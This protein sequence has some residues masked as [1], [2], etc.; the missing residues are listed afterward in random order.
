MQSGLGVFS[1]SEAKIDPK[2]IVDFS[3]PYLFSE[4]VKSFFLNLY[5]HQ[6]QEKILNKKIKDF[7]FFHIGGAS[8]CYQGIP[9]PEDMQ[10]QYLWYQTST[11]VKE[12]QRE[13]LFNMLQSSGYVVFYSG[14]KV[15]TF[16]V[17]KKKIMD[18]IA[19]QKANH[20][21]ERQEKKERGKSIR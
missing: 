3:L 16:E 7:G 8:L 2:K 12:R 21:E 6:D 1:K 4:G 14:K 20:E 19:Q 9:I 5:I 17:F 13:A 11:L 10:N 15:E 18:E